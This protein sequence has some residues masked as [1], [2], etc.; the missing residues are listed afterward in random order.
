MVVVVV[1]VHLHFKKS[2]WENNVS[3]SNSRLTALDTKKIQE[4]EKNVFTFVVCG[5]Y[6]EMKLKLLP[7]HTSKY[8]C[9]VWP[10]QRWKI[11]PKPNRKTQRQKFIIQWYT[12]REKWKE[13]KG[14][15]KEFGFDMPWHT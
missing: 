14:K 4:V 9:Q 1:V 6:G 15:I 7:S 5:A 3:H 8:R 13:K 11:E 12:K 10:K 2:K